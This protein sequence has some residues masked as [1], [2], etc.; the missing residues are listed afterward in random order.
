MALYKKKEFAQRCGLTGGNLSNYITRGHVLLS[1]DYID[2][3]IE[4]NQSF[5]KKWKE[6]MEGRQI[7]V[8]QLTERVREK[9]DED[10]HEEI[11]VPKIPNV[12]KAIDPRTKPPK[13]VPPKIVP[14]KG[15]K[16]SSYFDLDK[17]RKML[18]IQKQKLDIEK[19]QMALLK[20]H[21]QV[22]PTDLIK[23]LLAVHSKSITVAFKNACESIIIE[24]SK[25]KELDRNEVAEIRKELITVLNQAVTDSI[26]ISKKDLKNIVQEYSIK[27]G[28]GEHS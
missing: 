1:G 22:I 15:E 26:A 10:E 6:K 9:S 16:D 25:K 21:G 5:Y 4:K 20:A 28:V 13:I 12:Q 27:K 7:E 18:D 19:A 24:F 17:E 23:N 14:P 2:D 11:K 3:E 8:E